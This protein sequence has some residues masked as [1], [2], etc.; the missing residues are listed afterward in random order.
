MSNNSTHPLSLSPKEQKLIS[1]HQ[2]LYQPK[3]SKLSNIYLPNIDNV[4]KTYTLF[5][6]L[7]F[8]NFNQDFFTYFNLF[9]SPSSTE[10]V[11][12]SNAFRLEFEIS[13]TLNHLILAFDIYFFFDNLILVETFSFL[14][15]I[16]PD[17]LIKDR[18]FTPNTLHELI[19][20]LK[21]LSFY[22]EKYSPAHRFHI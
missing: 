15:N 11:Q 2:R 12:I 5:L 19:E 21:Q 13:N 18:Y 7:Y 22:C 6:D 1:L 9:D 3:K 20:F 14:E 10:S 17:E 16:F 4:A 8:S